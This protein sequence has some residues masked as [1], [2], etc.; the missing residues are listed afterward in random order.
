MIQ[1]Y[2]IYMIYITEVTENVI[3]AFKNII[4]DLRLPDFTQPEQIPVENP[5]Y[6][7]LSN[8]PDMYEHIG[9]NFNSQNLQSVARG[10]TVSHYSA[11]LED[12][13]RGRSNSHKFTTE[14][15]VS[16]PES[17]DDE[18]AHLPEEWKSLA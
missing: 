16:K 15:P 12:V 2:A 6:P 18:I 10:H 8:M 11:F 7:I 5:P 17:F 3:W 1:S 13:D 9:Q 14:D 4:Y